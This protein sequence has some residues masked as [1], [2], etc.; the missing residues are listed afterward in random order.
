MT[1]HVNKRISFKT[2]SS[3]ETIYTV[4]V[5]C[6]DVINVLLHVSLS[7]NDSFLI[8]NCRVHGQNVIKRISLL[9]LFCCLLRTTVY[10]MQ[11]NKITLYWTEIVMFWLNLGLRHSS[12]LKTIIF[13]YVSHRL[14]VEYCMTEKLQCFKIYIFFFLT[15]TS[16]LNT[17]LQ[18]RHEIFIENILLVK[19]DNKCLSSKFNTNTTH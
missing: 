8:L 10:L 6:I 9:T 4:K 16:L 13:P 5:S 2:C 1:S 18:E 15:I 19:L 7:N 11:T 14:Y 17:I 12:N 3:S